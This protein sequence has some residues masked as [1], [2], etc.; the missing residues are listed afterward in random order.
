MRD[1]KLVMLET[2]HLSQIAMTHKTTTLDCEFPIKMELGLSA[3]M[4]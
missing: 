4:G 2:R 3:A 1:A